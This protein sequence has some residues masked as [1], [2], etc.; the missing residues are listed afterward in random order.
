V[1]QFET[2]YDETFDTT[3][4]RERNVSL[5]NNRPSQSFL[6]NELKRKLLQKLILML[7]H[8]LKQGR[9]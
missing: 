1:N 3:E 7:F 9:M 5:I 4:E 2:W 6:R 8:T